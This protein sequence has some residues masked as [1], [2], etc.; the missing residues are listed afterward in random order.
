LGVFLSIDEFAYHDARSTLWGWPGQNP[1]RW[2]DPTGRTSD[3]NFSSGDGA[4]LDFGAP[5]QTPEAKVALGL[6]MAPYVVATMAGAGITL[7][8]MF[9]TSAIGRFFGFGGASA[10]G[11]KLNEGGCSANISN[12]APDVGKH[13]ALGL[14]NHGL[15]NTASKVGAET[16]LSDPNWRNSLQEAIANPNS[17]FTVALDG[18]SGSS[19]YTQVMNAVQ[20]GASTNAS[21]TNWELAQL[22]QAGMLDKVT[23]VSNGVAVPNP[24]AQ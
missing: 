13:I 12:A 20:Q 11:Q 5:P 21:P 4:H 6:A 16:L 10:V 7:G 2:R 23:F 8:W 17:R 19:P 1:Y 14:R 22:Y 9:P 24:F 18:L 15:E 3:E